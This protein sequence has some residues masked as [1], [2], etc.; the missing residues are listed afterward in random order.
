MLIAPG[1]AAG[2]KPRASWTDYINDAENRD[3]DHR[4]VTPASINP[5]RDRAYTIAGAAAGC[6]INARA[7]MDSVPCRESANSVRAVCRS[8]GAALAQCQCASAAQTMLKAPCADTLGPQECDL[9]MLQLKE[10]TP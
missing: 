1:Y 7:L 2:S 3:G 8:A 4:F 9:A 6:A 5:D 10:C